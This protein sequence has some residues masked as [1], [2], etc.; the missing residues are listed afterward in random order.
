LL[1]ESIKDVI[2]SLDMDLNYTY[3]SPAVE[4][5]QGWLPD[6]IV[7][8]NIATNLPPHS[9]ELAANTF[10][11]QLALSE[12]AGDYHR[13]VVL[14]IELLCKDGTTLWGEVTAAF[15]LG[16]DA[17][18]KGILGVVRDI[19]QRRRDRQERE[20]LQE[21]L[22]R[23]KKMEALGL[24]AGGVAH[25]LNNVLSGIV[26]YPDLLMIDMDEAHPMYHPIRA[27]RE[28]G[29]KAA[30]I[31]Q[32]LLTLARRGVVTTEILNLN[33]LIRQYL[34]SLEHKKIVSFHPSI[35]IRTKLEDH[36]PNVSGSVVHLKKTL[37]NLVSN[38]VEA[39]PNGGVITIQTCSQYLDRPVKGYDRV[40]D[41]EY[42]VVSVSDQGQGIAPADLPHIFEPFYTKKIMGRSGTGLGLA[43]V[44]GTVQDHNGYIDVKSDTGKGTCLSLYF[45]MTRIA[46]S[47]KD[48]PLPV[49]TYNGDGETIL[50]VD[51]VEMQRELAVDLLARLNYKA[52]SVSSGEDA[53]T[54]V[55]NHKV[56][57]LVLDMIMDPGLDGLDTYRQILAYRPDQ[58]A[59]I[60]SGFAETGRVKEAQRLGAAAYIRKPYTIEKIGLAVY[61]A[62]NGPKK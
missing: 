56:D 24:M 19:S 35:D 51:D 12:A 62:L 48:T 45:P 49:E 53:I 57:L 29:Q 15:L 52:A 50:V 60:A 9:I 3:V 41:G 11:K 46:A 43:V 32:D 37:M 4:D 59:I 39:Q 21:Q 17:M 6:E 25:D 36:L 18:P 10:E 5:M 23:S 2:F 42:V 1:T 22:V 40:D 13:F 8:T 54:Y 28:S 20:A 14:E 26:S 30:A 7:G 38:A 16:S 47:A 27:I 55:Q 61:Q 33:T 44:W 31:V 58:R 34:S